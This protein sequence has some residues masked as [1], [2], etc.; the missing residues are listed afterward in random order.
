LR[1]LGPEL[2]FLLVTSAAG[3]AARGR[4]LNPIG[5]TGIWWSLLG[6]ILRGQVL[7]RDIHLQYGPLSPYLLALGAKVFGLTATYLI[8]AGWLG[9]IACGLL[10]LAIARRAG[11]SPLAR[12]AVAA[13]ML[14]L[15]VFGPGV[16][17]LVLAY[18]PAA[19]HALALSLW[20]FLAAD[21]PPE[22]QRP[23][24]RA[25]AAGVL[26]GLALCAKPEI[27][28]AAFGCV[29]VQ[30]LFSDARV[31]RILAALAGFAAA[32]ATGLAF[33]LRASSDPTV[34][35][36]SRLWPLS[37]EVPAPWRELFRILMGV[38]S[39]DW[40][41]LVRGSA[42][43]L[44]L[45]VLGVAV[46]GLMLAR[47]GSPRGWIP[48]GILAAAVGAWWLVEGWLLVGRFFPVS[49][50]MLV[51]LAVAAW[52]LADRREPARR[53]GV[54]LAVSLFAAANGARAAFSTDLFGPYVKVS[55]FAAALTW[56]LFAA[57]VVPAV[58]AREERAGRAMR[59]VAVAVVLSVSLAGA[60]SSP[61]HLSPPKIVPYATRA[62]T[63]WIGDGMKHF[64]E[65]A[66]AATRPGESVAILPEV[67]AV[68]V[69]FGLRDPSPWLT[70]VPGWLDGDAEQELIRRFQASPPEAIVVFER[71]TWLFRTAPFGIGY[72]RE[73]S[74]WIAARYSPVV[75][76]PEGVVLRRSGGPA[77]APAARIIPV[78]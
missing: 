5:D 74:A 11:L 48:A 62:G 6:R 72:G 18:A 70:H 65:A 38:T 17:P 67:A 59:A 58:L 3:L 27:G 64:L 77:P 69:F 55:Q 14:P 36:R 52:A 51:S 2:A 37:T 19:V 8:L 34:W 56:V 63:V 26:A 46:A 33:V 42:W 39:P 61:G 71:P 25:V 47:E 73:L 7:Y 43:T 44:L 15:S 12:L 16:S 9:A 53:R 49:L 30:L 60:A 10:L 24:R 50:S 40:G 41:L 22:S 28:A 32:S 35:R 23:A 20:A 57:R 21:V 76:A 31:R 68:D 4:W 75:K 13:L 29:A 45:I 1:D 66:G 78:P 54:V